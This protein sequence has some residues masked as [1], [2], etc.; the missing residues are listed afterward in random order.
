M[1]REVVRGSVQ[2]RRNRGQGNG[3]DGAGVVAGATMILRAGAGLAKRG[4]VVGASLA[5]VFADKNI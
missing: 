2:A 1:S 4:Q 3:E 5:L